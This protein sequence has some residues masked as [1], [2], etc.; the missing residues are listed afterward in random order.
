LPQVA[1]G[2]AS[3]ENEPVKQRALVLL[4]L[5]GC[6]GGAEPVA[7]DLASPVDLATP[8]FTATFA[9][10]SAH[11]GTVL[12]NLNVWTVV[13]PGDEAVG[14]RLDAFYTGMF[15][16]DDYWAASLAQYG[17][18][19]GRSNGVIVLPEPK[20]ASITTSYFPTLV[21]QLAA[22]HPPDPETVFGFAVPAT[23]AI[24]DL[25]GG[26]GGYHDET[27][28]DNI[29]FMVLL[30]KPFALGPATET[31]TFVASHEAAETA[32]DPH[33]DT[34]AGWYNDAL[35]YHGEVG[36]LCEPL[37]A[38]I[39]VEGDGGAAT[40]DVS[41][42]YSNAQAAMHEDPCVPAPPGPYF[43]VA[44]DPANPRIRVGQWST[45]ATLHAFALGD[46]GPIDWQF[47]EATGAIFIS[48]PSGTNAAG[49]VVEV[50]LSTGSFYVPQNPVAII[51]HS[52][53]TGAR[54]IWWF[55][56]GVF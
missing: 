3:C 25:G 35:H 51:A 36:D 32:T 50:T 31:L 38:Q 13:W 33:P 54:N 18:G 49:D 46:V 47:V 4:L 26:V 12:A 44:V 27:T 43:N 15:A 20:P 22:A 21:H 8:P 17:V 11:T 40:W 37:N 39:T 30:Q 2:R 14:A 41:R 34:T 23:T 16:A 56:V 53:E 28:G 52:A 6:G 29:P 48:Q 24:S 55:E 7:D 9:Q 19:R 45:T 5:A 1:R 42:L 10:M